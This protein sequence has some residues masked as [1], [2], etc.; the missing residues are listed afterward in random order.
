M[1]ISVVLGYLC[2]VYAICS[3]MDLNHALL[4]PETD[5]LPA[6]TYIAT[7]LSGVTQLAK[8]LD[9]NPNTKITH[10]LL[11]D[12]TVQD[13]EYEISLCD[14]ETTLRENRAVRDIAVSLQRVLDKAAPSLEALSFLAHLTYARVNEVQDDARILALLGRSYPFLTQLTFR[15]NHMHGA[16]R[17][18]G[19]RPPHFPALTH[20]HVVDQH[21]VP[22]TLE[23]LLADY[24]Y[25]THLRISG[26]EVN[27]EEFCSS[28]MLDHVKQA[29]LGIPPISIP[30]NLTVTIDPGFRGSEFCETPRVYMRL[31]PT[32]EDY[33]PVNYLRRAITEFVDRARGEEGEWAIPEPIPSWWNR[34]SD[35]QE[36]DRRDESD[37]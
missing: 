27:A 30:E 6:G 32:E 21:K 31:F 11:S 33:R 12:S 1:R 10:L 28:T 22:W 7:G 26:S 25:L 29:V 24:P 15:N 34:P 3:A 14:D 5:S 17:I 4:T 20:L 36:A 2:G 8:Y 19:H 13:V 16:T 9:T 23:S 35:D 18:L 37:L